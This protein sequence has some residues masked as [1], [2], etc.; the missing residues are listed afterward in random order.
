MTFFRIYLISTE[1][2][3][4]FRNRLV[5]LENGTRNT[6]GRILGGDFNTRAFE[7]GLFQLDFSGTQILE[8]HVRIWIIVLNIRSTPTLCLREYY[9]WRNLC[10]VATVE[11]LGRFYWYISFEVKIGSSQCSKVQRMLIR[12]NNR[13]IEVGKFVEVLLKGIDEPWDPDADRTTATETLM[14]STI[15]FITTACDVSAPKSDSA[16]RS[17]L[18]TSG[19]LK[20]GRLQ[21]SDN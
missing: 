6:E 9:P 16:T 5:S 14:N 8:M 15:S 21:I 18:R 10:N 19:W 7:C 4:A 20:L 3:L 2:I 17:P 12:W 1:S 13:K 11:S